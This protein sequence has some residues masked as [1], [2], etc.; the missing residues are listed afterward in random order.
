MLQN[1][2]IKDHYIKIQELYNNAVN[3]L[4]AINQSFYSSSSEINVNFLDT[5]NIVN[6]IRIPSFLYLE[7]RIEQLDSNFNSLFEM[8][9]S[10]EAWF[11]KASDM[12]K[13]E[14]VHSNNAPEKPI[15]AD[16][17]LLAYVKDT[18][19]FRDLVNPKTYLKL[20]ISNLPDNIE[21]ILVKKILFLKPS[22]YNEVKNGNFTKYDE[23]KAFLYNLEKG[24]DYDEYDTVID[25]PIKENDYKSEF[26]ILDIP[27]STQNPYT[28]ENTGKLV[29]KVILDTLTYS[30]E[31]DSSIEHTLKVGQY[32]CLANDYAIYKVVEINSITN[33]ILQHEVL[34][35]EVTGHV[36][37][38]TF[39]QNQNMVL[40]L[41]N[42]NYSQYHYVEVPLEENQFISLFISTLYNNVKSVFSEAILLNL[43]EISIVDKNG[44]KIINN[45]KEVSYIEY[46]NKYCKNVGDLLLGFSD[47][48]YSQMSNYTLE[49]LADLQNGDV[50]QTFVTNTISVD[51]LK[52][53]RINSHLID[54]EY[55]SKIINLHSKRNELT[56]NI[57]NL[58]SN[59]D[60]IYNQ[61]VNIDF[62]NDSSVSQL[63]LKSKLDDL[64]NEKIIGQKQLIS[65]IDNI[66]IMKT[67]VYGTSQAKYRIRGN[68]NITDIENYLKENFQ[69]CNLIQMEVQ[70]KYKSI[71]LDTTNVSNINSNLFTDWNK[72]DTIQRERKIIFDTELHTYRLEF[73]N[74]DDLTNIIKWNQ[75]EIPIT[76]G[77][78]VIIRVRYKYSIGQ[79]FINIYT[80]WSDEFT[81]VF[82]QEYND[83]TELSAIIKQNDDD[84]ISAKFLK[85]LI[86]DGYSEHINNKVIDNSQKFFHMPENIYSG[87]NTPENSLISLKDKLQSM[88][89][90]INVYKEF[91]QNDV[92]SSYSLYLSF[93]DK[94]IP[95]LKNKDNQITI[96]GNENLESFTTKNMEIII[97]NT[98]TVP[99]KLYSL[100]PGNSSRKLI[101]FNNNTEYAY[102]SKIYENVP[103]VVE[104][105]NY[106]GQSAYDVAQYQTLGQFIYF[107][108]NSVYNIG[109]YYVNTS[110]ELNYIYNKLNECYNYNNSQQI[111]K[112]QLGINILTKDYQ[113]FHKINDYLS[114]GQQLT[115]PLRYRLENLGQVLLNGANIGL[116]HLLTDENDN[117]TEITSETDTTS[118]YDKSFKD[119]IEEVYDLMD[120]GNFNKLTEEQKI[121]RKL[122]NRFLLKYEHIFGIKNNSSEIVQLNS[123]VSLGFLLDSNKYEFKV[124]YEDNNGESITK[125]MLCGGFFVPNLVSKSQI[126]CTE[127]NNSYI[128]INVGDS[129]SVPLVFEYYLNS[130]NNSV[131]KTISFDLTKSLLKSTDNYVLS[132]T[133]KYN[134]SLNQDS[135]KE[136]NYLMDSVES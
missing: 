38:Q 117:I 95:L 2:T 99:L 65:V 42:K 96:S 125:S 39:D 123:D 53:Q 51:N 16:N 15:L 26:K 93:D 120:F 4:T 118:R 78:D 74:Y 98:G 33:D 71:T 126:L 69:K 72:L 106:A 47:V 122:E 7:N 81:I 132:V 90:D 88:S 18:N 11:H 17:K 70:Y 133:A 35:E 114:S 1:S 43:D 27:E 83:S 77:E 108:T 87:F 45:G 29:Y 136:S 134:S 3:I 54:D 12:Y 66:N 31:D 131:T 79:P 94:Q 19:I 104:G 80:P 8:P 86:N 97:K 61:L 21:K 20:N 91:I 128:Q 121:S 129:I 37:L 68:S 48:A 62:N 14:L 9:K 109:N 113:Y 34:L 101:E 44:Q 64:Y 85:T 76:Q 50:I 75:I 67:N 107:R 130:K 82:P 6:T 111:D 135:L 25:L 46:Y 32:I 124:K 92:D 105:E 58:Q 119:Y 102:N 55:T 24:I 84:E 13:L 49:Q 100:F 23:Y 127:D 22:I 56:N 103:I 89:N 52:V 36:T 63:S 112:V 30:K 28:N 57:D 41:Y 5:D 10:G 110:N 116:L 115:M 60:D 40:H 59:I 73:E